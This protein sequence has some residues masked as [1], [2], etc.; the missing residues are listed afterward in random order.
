MDIQTRH[1][2]VATVQDSINTYEQK[3]SSLERTNEEGTYQWNNL[4]K[5]FR[6]DP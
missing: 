4:V 6:Q 2:K 1:D 5:N 3:N